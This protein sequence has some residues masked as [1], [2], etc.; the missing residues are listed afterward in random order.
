MQLLNVSFISVLAGYPSADTKAAVA[1]CRTVGIKTFLL[2][3]AEGEEA[4]SQALEVGIFTKRSK[5]PEDIAKRL[6]MS[7]EEIYP[8]TTKSRI[9]KKEE[10]A[11]MRQNEL[12]VLFKT[13]S[14]IIFSGLSG[15][16]KYGITYADNKTN[17]IY[18]FVVC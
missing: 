10:M 6:N 15:G 8:R 13:H 17:T 2:T 9:V 1:Q 12:M 16:Q 7:V 14:E 4:R 18:L 11:K 3:S 5:T